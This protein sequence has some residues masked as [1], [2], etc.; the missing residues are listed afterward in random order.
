MASLTDKAEEVLDKV[1]PPVMEIPPSVEAK[2]KRGQLRLAELKAQRQ[3]AIEFT[4]NNHYVQTSEDKRSLKRF[5]VV[6]ALQGGGKVDHRVR[7]SHDLIGPIVKGKVSAA[8]QRIPGF[9]VDPATT[10]PEDYSAAKLAEKVLIAGYDTWRVKRAFQELVWNALVTE[11]GFIMAYWDTS[12][13]PFYDVSRHPQADEPPIMEEDG[14]VTPNPFADAPDPENPE[15]LGLGEVRL[16]VFGGLDVTWE[17][18]VK[19]EDSRWISIEQARP[20]DEVEGEPGYV[21]GKLTADAQAS[22]S[23]GGS[24]RREKGSNLALVT[25]YLE[26]PCPKYPN[27]R[28]LVMANKRLLFPEEDY[29]LRDQDGEIV[30]EPC[31]HRLAYTLDP[32]SDHDRGLVC[33][34]IESMRSYDFAKNKQDEFAQMGLVLQ[35]LAPE[36]SILTPRTDTPG[37]IIEYDPSVPGGQKPEFAPL[38][39]VPAELF[40]MENG[41]RA[42]M[43]FISHENEIPAQVEANKAVQALLERDQI[44]WADFLENEAD[45]FARIA[46]DILGLVQRHYTEDRMMKFRGR[47]GW[48]PIEDFKGSDLRGQTDVRVRSGSLEPQTRPAI[49][50]RIMSIAERFPGYFPPEVILGALERGNAEG[51]LQGYEEDVARANLIIAQIRAGTFW[52][53]PERP[54]WPGEDAVQLST[55]TGEPELDEQGQAVPAESVPGWMPRP[56]DNVTVT[57]S[58]FEIFL[59]SDEWNRLDDDAKS[60]SMAFYS[61][62]LDIETRNAERQREL[63]TEMAEEQGLSNAAKPAAP[64]PMPSLPQSPAPAE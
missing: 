44:S 60:A 9:E 22:T 52:D 5:P 1:K 19:F 63:Q 27:G 16:G 41:A 37:D 26:R 38:A 29:P 64:K 21:G 61:G 59:K 25:E 31:L 36:G 50:R 47:T 11:E 49:E 10:D 20:V 8:T 30:D 43:G 15:Y 39:G 2:I 54:V 45:V 17:P 13:G 53:Q 42:E 14:T 4:N 6:S 51:L 3:E 23:G 55:E 18:G 48:L 56:F 7:R 58:V 35:I 33:S 12:V 40:T 57:K 32:S 46:R 28:R 62:L 24:G 34:L